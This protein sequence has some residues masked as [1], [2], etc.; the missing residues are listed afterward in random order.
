MPL[1]CIS[2]HFNYITLCVIGIVVL[3]KKMVENVAAYA[4]FHAAASLRLELVVAL[5]K[6][7]C[8]RCKLLILRQAKAASV[9]CLLRG[10]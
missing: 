2:Q 3:A 7:D 6:L 9:H 4:L 1:Y 5:P 10:E 8:N